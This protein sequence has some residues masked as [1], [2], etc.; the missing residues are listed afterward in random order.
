M[1]YK[2]TKIRETD[3]VGGPG[4]SVKGGDGFMMTPTQSGRFVIQVI[5]KHV[6]QGRYSYWSGVPWGTEMRLIKNVTE[7]KTGNTWKPL[8]SVNPAWGNFK[9]SQDGLSD[10]IR[11]R[12]HQLGYSGT[13]P[14]KWVF[15]DFG[16]IAVK[17]FKDLNNNGRMDGR[18]AIMGDFIHTTPGD[19]Y[20]TSINQTPVLHGSHGCIHV[21]PKDIDTL[22]Y[23]GYVKRGNI[24]EV[25]DYTEQYIPSV[26]MR[27]HARPGYEVHFFPGIEKI[28]IYKVEKD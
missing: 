14:D 24:I 8:T 16:H 7:V 22:I 18:E 4:K 9:N 20:L 17:Y 11:N 12:F 13:F 15:N 10:Y 6:S 26:L 23:L 25:H 2:L 19:E 27:Q 21:K 5:E 3:A 1:S 28:V